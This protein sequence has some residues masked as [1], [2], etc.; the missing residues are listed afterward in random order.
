[1]AFLF[2][3]FVLVPATIILLLLLV[4]VKSHG[5][6]RLLKIIG[7][8]VL[9]MFCLF[10]IG[11]IAEYFRRFKQSDVYGEYIIDRTKFSGRQA[12]WQYNH[13]RFEITKQNEFLFYQTDNETIIKTNKG[14][15]K[16][17]DGYKSAR[18]VLQVDS[19]RHH[20][21]EDKP[22]LYSNGKPFYYVF[23]SPKFGNVFF[24]QKDIG[25]HWT[26]TNKQTDKWKS[27]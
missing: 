12:D 19:P 23:Q 9:G 18:I 24:L 7:L 8:I 25:N 26:T 13:F 2:F 20:I 5:A 14:K 15:V 6:L 21:I 11:N 3:I 1:M 4:F 22:T 16:F 10:I 27:N 17:L